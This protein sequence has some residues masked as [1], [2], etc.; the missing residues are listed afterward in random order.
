M[1][2]LVLWKNP[3]TT[4]CFFCTSTVGGSFFFRSLGSLSLAFRPSAC[5]LTV[6]LTM[7]VKLD[8]FLLAHQSRYLVSIPFC[9]DTARACAQHFCARHP[10]QSQ[11]TSPATP[12]TATWW[13]RSAEK[14]PTEN[15]SVVPFRGPSKTCPLWRILLALL[16]IPCLVNVGR[17]DSRASSSATS[18]FWCWW[19]VGSG[20]GPVS[21]AL[22]VAVDVDVDVNDDFLVVLPDKTEDKSSDKSVLKL[23]LRSLQRNLSLSLQDSSKK[24]GRLNF[25]NL[26][27]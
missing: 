7:F 19:T 20:C 23:V 15:Q 4:I 21:S 5:L 17:P 18:I 8:W 10:S 2:R 24:S 11:D 22:H 3:S 14:H 9:W 26:F 12:L 16:M 13:G 1:F 25:S 6:M 27:S